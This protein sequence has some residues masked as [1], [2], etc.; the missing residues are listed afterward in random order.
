VPDQ[1]A[2]D[3]WR[4]L[5]GFDI[6]IQ[7]VLFDLGG[8]IVTFKDPPYFAELLN[9]TEDPNFMERW[10]ASPTVAAYE[11]GKLDRT[12]F[13]D[14]IIREF[15][16]GCS[17]D[18]FLQG[19]LDWPDGL[20]DG[21][22]MLVRSLPLDLKCGCLSNTSEL[23]WESQKQIREIRGL[24]EYPFL[25]FEMGLMKPDPAIYVRAAEILETP[26]ENI[27]FF[28]DRADNVEGA[29]SA[30]FQAYQVHG[31]DAAQEIINGYDFGD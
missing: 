31:A 16:L 21:A 7:A 30:G 11:S 22:E 20:F 29:L 4:V 8:V 3:A 5:K 24:F 26:P 19:F 27:L 25:S 1:C 18:D 15:S 12:S 9:C 10:N 6:S 28:D 14:G 2:P 17:A 13:A 23:H